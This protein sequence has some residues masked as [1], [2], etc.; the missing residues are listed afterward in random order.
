MKV[1]F[2]KKILVDDL[3]LPYCAIS[4]EI[5]GTSRWNIHHE[6]IFE[7]EG[8]FYRTSYSEGATELQDESPW[9]YD[10]EVECEQVEK[11]TKMVEVTIWSPIVGDSTNAR[12]DT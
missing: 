12:S 5:T 7:L 10:N 11:I 8:K 2:P 6:I 1:K 3:E 4:D 9:E